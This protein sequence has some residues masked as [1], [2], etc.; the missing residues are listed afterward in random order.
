[1]S[2]SENLTEV[3]WGPSHQTRPRKEAI[4][5]A[6]IGRLISFCHLRHTSASLAV[7]NGTPLMVVAQ[8]LGHSV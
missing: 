5:N 2:F 6:R 4:K 3:S 7:M 8:N 1:M